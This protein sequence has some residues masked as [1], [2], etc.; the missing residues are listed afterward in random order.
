VNRMR[1]R[2]ESGRTDIA[3]HRTD[4][5]HIVCP[6]QSIDEEDQVGERKPED[7]TQCS[8]ISSTPVPRQRQ[9]DREKAHKVPQWIV[10][11]K[12]FDSRRQMIV[13]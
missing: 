5:E 11:V 2:E 7:E 10:G 8:D 3:P 1:F 12:H 9:E 6:N 4:V 13:I